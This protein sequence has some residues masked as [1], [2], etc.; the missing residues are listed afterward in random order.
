MV[1]EAVY[2]G[3]AANFTSLPDVK[4]AVNFTDSVHSETNMICFGWVEDSVN[5]LLRYEKE[6]YIIP[7]PTSVAAHCELPELRESTCI[8]NTSI[9]VFGIWKFRINLHDIFNIP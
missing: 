8:R 1:P 5:S 3:E 2:D 9:K 7:P 6:L 4:R